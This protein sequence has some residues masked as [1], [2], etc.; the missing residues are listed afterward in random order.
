MSRTHSFPAAIALLGAAM[1]LLAGCTIAPDS[2][3]EFPPE[4]GPAVIR[5]REQEMCEVGRIRMN[6]YLLTHAPIEDVSAEDLYLAAL[7]W[8][9]A[10]S[11]ADLIAQAREMLGDT[12]ADGLSR[13]LEHVRTKSERPYSTDCEVHDACLAAAAGHGARLALE[14]RGVYVSDRDYQLGVDTHLSD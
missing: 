8:Q 5:T 3:G 11:S 12:Y 14:H 9:K 4:G 1:A 7:E 2:C 6:R 10:S 13:A